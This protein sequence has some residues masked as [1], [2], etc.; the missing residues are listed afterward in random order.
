MYTKF[1]TRNIII[2]NQLNVSTRFIEDFHLNQLVDYAN[3]K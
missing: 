2:L 1:Q 3:R